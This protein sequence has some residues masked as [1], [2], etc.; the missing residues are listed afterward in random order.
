VLAWN[1]EPDITVAQLLSIWN[2]V[3]VHVLLI[4]RRPITRTRQD[5]P[6]REYAV[7]DSADQ[8]ILDPLLIIGRETDNAILL[9]HV[10]DGSLSQKRDEAL[11]ETA[12][13]KPEGKVLAHC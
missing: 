10:F 6:R 2:A 1:K 5:L 7:S 8:V 3:A 9:D 4:N 13:Q 12:V 11:I